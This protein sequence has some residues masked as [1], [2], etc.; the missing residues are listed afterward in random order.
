M[1]ARIGKVDGVEPWPARVVRV[2]RGVDL[3]CAILL[4]GFAIGVTARGWWGVPGL[5]PLDTGPKFLQS[6]AS[7]ILPMTT[8]ALSFALLVVVALP[9]T[10]PRRLAAAALAVGACGVVLLACM[11]LVPWATNQGLRPLLVGAGLVGTGIAAHV[12]LAR[13]LWRAGAAP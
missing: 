3:A 11:F 7:V 13:W 5:A 10:R 1:A 9:A 6:L 12:V 4:L 8:V 2:F